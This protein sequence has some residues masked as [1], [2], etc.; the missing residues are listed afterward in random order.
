MRHLTT[1]V[2]EIFI[3]DLAQGEKYKFEIRARDGEILKKTD[4]LARAF[5]A[6]PQTA[7]IV[8]DVSG[9][10]W[11]DAPWMEARGAE[12]GWLE[13]P[14][15]AYEVHLGSWALVPEEG[16]RFLTYRELAHR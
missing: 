9:Y 15:S 13:K 7:A 10:V 2:W 12:G 5:E 14:V 4:P 6:P 8:H 11:Q 3:P 1:G 16:N